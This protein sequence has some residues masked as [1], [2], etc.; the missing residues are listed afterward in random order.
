MI[1]SKEE[2]IRELRKGGLGIFM[3]EILENLPRFQSKSAKLLKCLATIREAGWE[4][5]MTAYSLEPT[6]S[7]NLT[8][9]TWVE[10]VGEALRL[11]KI[12][13]PQVEGLIEKL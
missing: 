10:M 5:G 12:T 7:Y 11:G 2:A 13:K 3:V 6:I 4:V 1:K 9:W 8:T